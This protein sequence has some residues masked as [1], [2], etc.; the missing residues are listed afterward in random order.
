MRR[1]L[2]VLLLLV[3]CSQSPPSGPDTLPPVKTSEQPEVYVAL[4]FL[5]PAHGI[6]RPGQEITLAV[7]FTAP[8][9]AYPLHDVLPQLQEPGEDGGRQ[10]DDTNGPRK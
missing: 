9:S 5:P 7:S 1:I 3:G 6:I 8:T 10:A 2:P 4:D